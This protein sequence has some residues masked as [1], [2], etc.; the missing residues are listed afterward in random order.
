MNETQSALSTH[1]GSTDFT[2]VAD[3]GQFVWKKLDQDSRVGVKYG[4]IR[5]EETLYHEA[6]EIM[7]DSLLQQCS[8]LKREVDGLQKN[9]MRAK[10]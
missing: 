3:S 7:L 6:A 4:Y 9:N 10:R 8:D 5:L 2:Y 1:G